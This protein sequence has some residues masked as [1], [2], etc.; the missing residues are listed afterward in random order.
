MI[1]IFE[2]SLL[3]LWRTSIRGWRSCHGGRQTRQQAAALDDRGPRVSVFR[4]RPMAVKRSDTVN[5]I[6]PSVYIAYYT[7]HRIKTGASDFTSNA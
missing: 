2:R 5:F 3:L 6:P 4:P 1:D 7:V